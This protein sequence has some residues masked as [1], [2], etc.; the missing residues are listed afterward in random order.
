MHTLLEILRKSENLLIERGVSEARLDAEHLIAA[1]LKCKRMDLYLQ[2]DRPMEEEILA[3]L[4][5]LIARRARR[6]PLSYI[7]GHHP[8]DNLDLTVQPGILIPRPET[9]ELVR[10]TADQLHSAPKRILD[11]GTGSGAIGLWMKKRYPDSEVVAVDS[12][13]KA[14]E[15]S[16][17]NAESN[18]VHVTFLESDWFG[19]IE[20]QFD[21]I[22]SNPPYLTDDEWLAAEPEVRDHE[23]KTAL[24][25]GEDGIADLR[26]ILKRAPE[27][28]RPGGLVALETG[29]RHR[30][31]LESLCREFEYQ[32]SWGEDDFSGRN[33]YFFAKN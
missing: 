29:I 28:L 14:L 2:F 20:G 32:T 23:P 27:Y 17:K 19:Q 25:A 6:E 5:P 24:V 31:T 7:L 1:T 11:L 26:T 22:I 16:R 3:Q 30:E 15:L 9:E 33:R 13:S 18:S 10:I 4:R 12:S 21:L 8:F